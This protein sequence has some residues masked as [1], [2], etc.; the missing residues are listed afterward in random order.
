MYRL[1]SPD[2]HMSLF[3]SNQIIVTSRRFFPTFKNQFV[4][5]AHAFTV[6]PDGW[7]ALL[8]QR[9]RW[10]NS[11]VHNLGELI[12]LE[13][14]RGS[15]CFSMRFAVVIDLIVYLVYSVAGEHNPIPTTSLIMLA[16]IYGLQALVFIMRRKMDDFSW[17]QTHVFMGESGKKVLVHVSALVLYRSLPC[18]C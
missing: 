3:I 11:T 6:A 12:W 8:P 18:S 9:R 14:L 13:Q 10:I 15:C 16:A 4:C 2:N 5:D 17:G 1:R 7:K